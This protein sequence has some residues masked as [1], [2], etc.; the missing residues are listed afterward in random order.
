M[1]LLFPASL[2]KFNFSHVEDKKYVTV[3]DVSYIY[4]GSH[5]RFPGSVFYQFC[6]L[7]QRK[8]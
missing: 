5:D 3:K 2:L 4:P 8:V 7:R 1:T 6:L